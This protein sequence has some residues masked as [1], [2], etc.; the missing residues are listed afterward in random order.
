MVEKQRE[1][2]FH[3]GFLPDALF[4]ASPI[5]GI[6]RLA[7]K[8]LYTFI[9]KECC[10]L[11]PGFIAEHFNAVEERIGISELTLGGIARQILHWE[12]SHRHCSV[13]GAI[14]TPSDGTWGMICLSCG[15]E[16]FPS[17]SPCAI[18]LVKRGDQ[19]LLTRKSGWPDGRYSLVAGFVDFGESLEE[20][21]ER[22]V[23]EET[24]IKVCNIRYVGSQSWPF[25]SQLMAGFTADYKSGEIQVDRCE[26]ED[27]RWFSMDRLPLLPPRRSIA[28]WIIERETENPYGRN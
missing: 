9:L 24:G 2:S 1:L 26:L 16:H 15:R 27:A 13:C 28:R 10:E 25:P 5:L 7:G 14:L 22:E 21:A 11:P 19:F 3:E 20:C 8:S 6:G 18:V 23:F 17:I 12:K 4:P